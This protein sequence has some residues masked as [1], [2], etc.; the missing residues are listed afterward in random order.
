MTTPAPQQKIDIQ[1]IRTTV[2]RGRGR[3]EKAFTEEQVK[4]AAERLYRE[5]GNCLHGKPKMVK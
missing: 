3:V 4:Q 1:A 5:L 2:S